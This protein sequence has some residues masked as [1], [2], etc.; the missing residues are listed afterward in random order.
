MVCVKQNVRRG[1]TLIELLVVIV[2]IAV[3][4]AII[5]PKFT[6]QSKRSKE[7]ALKSDLHLV[8][9]ALAN[10]QADTGLWVAALADLSGAAAPGTNGYNTS[11]VATAWPTGSW[12]GPY[13]PAP[14]PTDPVSG[15]AFTYTNTT[16]TVLS[17]ATGNDTGGTA[18]STY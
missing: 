9:N 5:I 2:V 4:A 7:A 16:G 8:R 15:A 18:Y 11:A 1:F 12:H 10:C 3:L 14:I 17:S 6:D 13:L